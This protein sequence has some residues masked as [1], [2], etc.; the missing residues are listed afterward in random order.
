VEHALDG[1]QKES[2]KSGG[3]LRAPAKATLEAPQPFMMQLQE[4]AGNQAVQ[5]FLRSCVIHAKLAISSPDDPE[6]REA[7]HVAHTI[8]RS[9]AGSAA[10]TPCSCS[11]DG[12][13]CE[14]CQQKKSHATIHRRASTPSAPSDVPRI[15]SDVLHSPG[16]PLDS[17]T[18]SF[19][20]PRFG[21]DF[22]HVR[23]HTGPDAADSAR[24]VNAHA[25]AAVNHIV[26][27]KSEYAP[28]TSEGKK[29]LA[30]ELTHTV[31]Q[32]A[33][34]DFGQPAFSDGCLDKRTGTGS[35][36]KPH[37]SIGNI[38]KGSPALLQ[39]SWLGD[40]IEY[41][42]AGLRSNNW[43][44]S[45]PPGAYYIFNGL[46]K[47]DMDRVY[48]GLSPAE[49]KTLEDNLEKTSLDRP[50][51]Y[52]GIQQA[53][54]GGTWWRDKSEAVGWA[55][56]SEKFIEYPDGAFWIINPLNVDDTIKIMTFLDRDHLAALIVNRA[57]AIASGV[58]NAAR[59]VDDATMARRD[60][61]G[62]APVY[63][64]TAATVKGPEYGHCREINWTIQWGTQPTMKNGF[65]VQEIRRI[66]KD[67]RDT[68][69]NIDPS[70]PDTD[71]TYWE[72][73]RVDDDGNIGVG[74]VNE[75]TWANAARPWTKGKWEIIGKAYA[76]SGSLDPKAKFERGKVDTAR[77]LRATEIR[78]DNLGPPSLIRK[79]NG[80]WD[81]TDAA[82]RPDGFR[83]HRPFS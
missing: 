17:A 4:Q 79:L 27:G 44:N 78:P 28:D 47:E 70:R 82:A 58:P 24:A 61:T 52:Q 43:D 80:E 38:T 71:K 37:Q 39:R 60:R 23:I 34:G 62:A 83:Y 65:I 66:S 7:D 40:Q 67:N 72:A 8:M 59:I 10:A 57:N 25:Y 2:G 68:K 31:Q 16:H 64:V 14:E 49:R 30:H 45:D 54:A 75:D 42:R 19:F 53:K 11:R 1:K 73:W 20:E 32:G 81:C 50:R 22:S 35:L 51:M 6:E 21:H 56:R 55:I 12:E 33:A 18:R 48:N 77:M 29:L 46:S 9:H 76:V 41:V 26:F 5:E 13:T 3:I 63:A 15:V 74:D 36:G 69:G